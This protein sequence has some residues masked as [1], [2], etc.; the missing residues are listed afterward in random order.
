MYEKEEKKRENHKIKNKIKTNCFL[1]KKLKRKYKRHNKSILFDMFCDVGLQV[2]FASFSKMQN[3]QIK[4]RR[5][6]GQ[7]RE[8]L[9]NFNI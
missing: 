6:G 2:C 5:L 3:G 1:N 4:I 7:E 8:E 9:F